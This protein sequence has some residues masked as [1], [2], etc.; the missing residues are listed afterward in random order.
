MPN[1][2]PRDR[3]FYPTLTLMIETYNIVL[4][5]VPGS[6]SDMETSESSEGHEELSEA[7]VKALKA[8]IAKMHQKAA[9]EH[10]HH[11]HIHHG[12]SS[13]EMDSEEDEEEIDSELLDSEEEEILKVRPVWAHTAHFCKLISW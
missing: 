8:K 9:H 6:D 4:Y 13:E 5:T 2:D 10:L 1:V 12:E 3:F 7:Q 11:K